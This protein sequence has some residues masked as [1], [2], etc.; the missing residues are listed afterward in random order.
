MQKLGV[1]RNIIV[2]HAIQQLACSCQRSVV[3]LKTGDFMSTID[4]Q[5]ICDVA[6][7]V[8]SVIHSMRL[9]MILRTASA[10]SG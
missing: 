7:V 3:L 5:H 1:N 10:V 4:M 9:R 6:V 2:P 8:V